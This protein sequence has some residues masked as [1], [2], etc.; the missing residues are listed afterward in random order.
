MISRSTVA[1]TTQVLET[2]SNNEQL[3]FSK[4]TEDLE[5]FFKVSLH[6]RFSI[7]EL[8]LSSSSNL[9]ETK[10]ENVTYLFDHVSH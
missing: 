1:V 9:T 8:V 4:M 3:Q 5:F 10:T 7:R 2:I 6:C